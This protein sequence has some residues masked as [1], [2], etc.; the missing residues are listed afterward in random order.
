MTKKMQN[1][2]IPKTQQKKSSFGPVSSISSAPI[3]IGNSL[4]G[5]KPIVQHSVDGCRIRGR[6][7]GFEM[8]ASVA[9][10]NGWTLVG[11]LPLTPAAMPATTLKS[12]CQM[13]GLF[14]FNSLSV[15]YITS[16]P[17]TQAG[18]V[19]F[20]YERDRTGPAPDPTSSSF[21]PF[22]LSDD[23][24]VIGPQWTN[25]TAIIKP[26]PEFKSTDYGVNS[27]LNEEVNGS[28]FMY[29]KTNAASS[30]GYILL[31]YDITFK[32]VQSNP[33]AGLLPV[34]RAQWT[35]SALGVTGLAVVA[36]S[37]LIPVIQGKTISGANAVSPPGTQAGDIFKCI[38]D[39]T[40]ST[41]TAGAS[42]TNGPWTNVTVNNLLTLPD[43]VVGNVAYTIDDGFTCYVTIGANSIRMYPTLANALTGTFPFNYGVTATVTWTA[44]VYLSLVAS[45]NSRLQTSY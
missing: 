29:S 22:V 32:Q 2:R 34:V 45:Q 30:P 21:L 41:L 40:N 38:F 27:D 42:G 10:A 7:F 16:S 28:I 23:N 26:D 31:D 15:H 37:T 14:K 33:R 25:H 6:D 8:G 12:Y 24:T 39:V 5:S 19:V 11:G 17:T 3:A 4:R 36:G 44:C 35:Q 20:Y 18:D 1:V 13:Y 43:A 9:L